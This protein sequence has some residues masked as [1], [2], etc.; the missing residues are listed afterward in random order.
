MTIQDIFRKLSS[1]LSGTPSLTPRTP[2]LR[3]ADRVALVESL[4]Q[5]PFGLNSHNA[6]PV[7]L[8]RFADIGIRWHRI[9]IEW[10]L[11]E[12]QKNNFDWGALD[13]VVSAATSRNLSLIGLIA[14]SP[15]WAVGGDAANE[16]EERRRARMP[17]NPSDYLDFIDAV[18]S[19][20]E[21]NFRVLSI[22]N[23]PNLDQFFRG[24]QNEY[25]DRLL[26]PA[27]NRIREKAPSIVLAG[28]DLSSSGNPLTA[29]GRILDSAG[30]LFDVITHHQYDGG[31][32]PR[33]RATEIEKLRRFIVAR[34]YGD[35]PIWITETG[36]QA[37][38]DRQA[39]LLTAMMAE[40]AQRSKWWTKTFWY[41]SHGGGWGILA[42][43]GTPRGDPRPAFNAY[44]EVIRTSANSQRS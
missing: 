12:R 11:V 23:E 10:N 32:T 15:A 16:P 43:D 17:V 24:T 44:A 37:T 35:R 21:K 20:Y 42:D 27:L 31:D 7:Y 34:G 26:V 39:S 5:S 3:A 2:R 36:W 18:L 1:L 9:D 40:M 19:R 25:I 4:D 13:A 14:Y 33:G 22:W 29:L 6:P 41:D 30:D 38:P 8:E 28:P